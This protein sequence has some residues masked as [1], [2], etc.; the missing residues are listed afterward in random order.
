LAD[1]TRQNFG[2]EARR[3]FTDCIGHLLPQE[4]RPCRGHDLLVG[5]CG[6]RRRI[7][8]GETTERRSRIPPRDV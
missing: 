6:L 4:V 8:G 2:D 7:T 3:C 1:L 5:P